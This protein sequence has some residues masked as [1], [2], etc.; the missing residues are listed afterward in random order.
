MDSLDRELSGL[1]TKL[2]KI[3]EEVGGTKKKN[4]I[5]GDDGKSDRFL[6]IKADIIEKLKNIREVIDYMGKCLMLKFYFYSL[7]NRW[8]VK[9][10]VVET[11]KK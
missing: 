11:Q 1:L 3:H 9:I 6:E 2:G 4:I 8:E 5:L 7:L 10:V